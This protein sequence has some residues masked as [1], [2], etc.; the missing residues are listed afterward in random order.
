LRKV[1]IYA[2]YTWPAKH[3]YQ[4]RWAAAIIADRDDVA[5]RTLFVF[6]H[7][8]E[9]INKVI[10]STAAG[11]DDN[12]LGFEVAIHLHGCRYA[13][14]GGEESLGRHDDVGLLTE[15][16]MLIDHTGHDS[17]YHVMVVVAK[18]LCFEAVRSTSL[19]SVVQEPCTRPS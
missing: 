18:V 8:G 6:S 14:A 12:A 19:E 7:G 1:G 3:S 13:A 9:D 2:I 16:E 4:L 11:K 17:L 15:W 5:Q 10:R